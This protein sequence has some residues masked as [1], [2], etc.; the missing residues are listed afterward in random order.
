MAKYS[1]EYY[2]RRKKEYRDFY[3][4]G[5][6]DPYEEY[7]GNPL[8]YDTDWGIRANLMYINSTPDKGRSLYMMRK[9]TDD[10]LGSILRR[11]FKK[12]RHK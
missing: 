11:S 1:K 12:P 7:Y 10:G 9:E 4:E 6:F 3:K 2:R 5:D 8:S